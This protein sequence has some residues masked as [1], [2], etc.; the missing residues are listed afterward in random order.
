V[1]LTAEDLRRINDVLP[2]GSAA[3]ERYPAGAM[4]AVNL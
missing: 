1:R 3:G 2:L 4:R